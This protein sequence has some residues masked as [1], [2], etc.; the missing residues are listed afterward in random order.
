[1]SGPTPKARWYRL[2]PDRPVTFFCWPPR[3]CFI[4]RGGKGTHRR[5]VGV[6][7]ASGRPH[8]RPE[9]AGRFLPSQTATSKRPLRPSRSGGSRRASSAPEGENRLPL[10]ASQ[11]TAGSPSSTRLPGPRFPQSRPRGLRRVWPSQTLRSEPRVRQRRKQPGTAPG[12]R[13]G[14]LIAAIVYMEFS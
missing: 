4:P 11:C 1:M 7:A 12:A 13:P 10:P 2:T 5:R 8:H 9:L 6:P 14:G 3:G